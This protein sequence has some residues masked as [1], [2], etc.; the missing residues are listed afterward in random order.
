MS[1]KNA[2]VFQKELTE[3]EKAEAAAAANAKGG[4]QPPPP[5]KD[6][7]KGPEE[8][9]KEELERLDKEKKEREEKER[10]LKEEWDSLDEDTKFFRTAEDIFKQ[11]CVKFNNAPAVKRIEQLQAQLAAAAPETE[12]Y[13]LLQ[14][15]VADLQAR[16]YTGTVQADKQ[17]FELVEFEEWVQKDRGCWV[18]FMK[19]LPAEE[20]AADPKA[21]AAKGA[22]A[23]GAPKGG[24]PTSEMKP[25]F[26]RGWLSFEALTQP[27]SLEV[28]QR[29]F[30]ETC[31]PMVKKAGED[32]VERFVPSEEP[33][34]PVFEQNK[35]Y[36]YVK[37]TMSEPVTPTVAQASE[38]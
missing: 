20:A 33:L 18:R 1:L 15:Q 10:K 22:P 28:K 6:A 37:L 8:P 4:K 16:I 31:Q 14:E 38:P 35:T 34:D 19:L 21:A 32:G 36:L 3:E 9:S 30:L 12:E 26:G 5:A 7:K 17:G 11:P 13:R 25:F 29:V 2:K 27:G 24:A 23:K